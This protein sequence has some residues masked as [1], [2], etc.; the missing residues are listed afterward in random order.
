MRLLHLWIGALCREGL[1]DNTKSYASIHPHFWACR[2]SGPMALRSWVSNSL[3]MFIHTRSAVKAGV[4]WAHF[5]I[6]VKAAVFHSSLAFASARFMPS[7]FLRCPSS[8]S[9]SSPCFMGNVPLDSGK[10]SRHPLACSLC[11]RKPISCP[12]C[13]PRT[14]HHPHHGWQACI[15]ALAWTR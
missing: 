5:H 14:S 8:G 6:A 12:A 11:R 1:S 13:R 9:K 2:M 4:E 3:G 10:R 7:S 15:V